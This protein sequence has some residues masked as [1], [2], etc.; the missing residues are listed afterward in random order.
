[1]VD[2]FQRNDGSAF[3]TPEQKRWVQLERILLKFKP[4]KPQEK[5]KNKF[6]G[7]VYDL[8]NHP[9]FAMFITNMIL[10]NGVLMTTFH[11]DQSQGWSQ[12]LNNANFFFVVI[13]TFEALAKIVAFTLGGYLSKGWNQ[14]DAV[15][16]IGSI[17]TMVLPG[18]MTLITPVGRIFR[19]L[20]LTRFANNNKGIRTLLKTLRISLPSIANLT[21]LFALLL[22]VFAAVAT[23]LYGGIKYGSSL[24]PNAN[25]RHFGMSML[26]L[27]QII[28]G[29]DWSAVMR[30]C[31]VIASSSSFFFLSG[32]LINTKKERKK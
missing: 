6:R 26:T 7:F 27:F 3:L 25:F 31:Q 22:F 18:G 29:D 11:K 21:F 32:K 17:L 19:I 24:N 12:F 2:Q 16:I 30:D 1:M 10:L 9:R 28:A 20:R 13:F 5:P 4:R 15:I 14:F 8:V 23:Q